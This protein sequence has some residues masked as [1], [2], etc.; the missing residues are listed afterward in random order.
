MEIYSFLPANTIPTIFRDGFLGPLRATLVGHEPCLGV[1]FP[2]GA[3][4]WTGSPAITGA[5]YSNCPDK[6]MLDLSDHR[7]NLNRLADEEN[8]NNKVQSINA[9]STEYLNLITLPLIVTRSG[10]YLKPSA[11]LKANQ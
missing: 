8:S 5:W 7:E 4:I 9:L 1:E 11:Q 2:S 3:G 6:S 10:R